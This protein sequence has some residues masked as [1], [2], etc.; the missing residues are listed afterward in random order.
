MILLNKITQTQDKFE[1]AKRNN[2]RIDLHVHTKY[3]DAT[4]TAEELIEEAK[5]SNVGI[6]SVT[7]H[8][9]VDFYK[10][11]KENSTSIPEDLLLINGIEITCRYDGK[12]RDILGYN[13]NCDIIS[14]WLEEKYPFVE[15]LA[16]QKQILINL[17]ILAKR[18]GLA[19]DDSVDVYE[20]KKSEAYVTM[21]LE[22]IKYPENI[23]LCPEL[24]QISR[25]HRECFTNPE[26]PLFVDE[27][28]DCPSIE[29]AIKI[30]HKAGGK[31]FVAHPYKYRM[32]DEDTLKYINDACLFGADGI[33]VMHNTNQDN[34]VEK[35]YTIA[36]QYDLLISGGSDFHGHLKP[37]VKLGYGKNNN[38]NIKYFDI[39]KWIR[40]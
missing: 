3:S 21:Y 22:L 12:M 4:H 15:R 32:S 29:E 34:D 19:F 33:E 1:L 25:F 30:I 28:Y 16:K 23:V 8:D 35:L 14:S 20:G 40:N 39:E 26:S 9:S 37:D 2:K 5:Q 10:R 11:I 6:L 13:I 36:K 38:V 27:T 18:F 31:A 24:K 7:D 17:K